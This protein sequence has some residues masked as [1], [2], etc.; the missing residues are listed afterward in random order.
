M[1]DDYPN[2]TY[3]EDGAYRRGVAAFGAGE[4][5][6]ARD[7]LEDFIAKFPKSKLRGEAEFFLGDIY[8]NVNEVDLALKHYKAVELY[9]KIRAL[10]TMHICRLPS[11]SITWTGTRR[12]RT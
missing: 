1:I 11:F 8:A 5:E 9:T 12:N 4:F 7:T 2:G 6:I 10:S 3:S